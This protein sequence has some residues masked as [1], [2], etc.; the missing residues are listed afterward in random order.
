[1]SVPYLNNTIVTLVLVPPEF[2]RSSFQPLV[3]VLVPNSL[4]RELS[5][6]LPFE[7]SQVTDLQL[8]RT[9]ACFHGAT[10][11]VNSQ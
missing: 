2:Y 4:V 5:I 11:A 6:T 3:T 9:S 10:V 7:H 1:M 8:G